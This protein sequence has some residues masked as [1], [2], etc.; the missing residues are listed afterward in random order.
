MSGSSCAWS[1][2][3]SSRLSQILLKI[4]FG[5]HLPL[6]FGFGSGL[7]LGFECSLGR[8]ILTGYKLV[9]G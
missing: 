7:S 2:N 9:I 6:V 1:S 4:G 3:S 8:T 5:W